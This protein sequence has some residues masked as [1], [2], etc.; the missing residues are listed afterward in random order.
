MVRPTILFGSLFRDLGMVL[1]IDAT[2]GSPSCCARQVE[3]N[4]GP[5]KTGSISLSIAV[6][7]LRPQSAARALAGGG[8][9]GIGMDARMVDVRLWLERPWD[10]ASP[11]LAA[12]PNCRI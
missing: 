10:R 8:L 3:R 6:V 9:G 1:R 11:D 12:H 5:C 2:E 7:E 4:V